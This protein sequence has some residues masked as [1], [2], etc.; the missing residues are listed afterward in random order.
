MKSVL[1]NGNLHHLCHA[2][3][4]ASPTPIAAVDGSGH[5][6]RYVNPAFC[7][8]TG[9]DKANLIGCAFSSVLSTEDDCLPMLARVYR[10]G[11]PEVHIGHDGSIEHPLFWSYTMSPIL[12]TKGGRIGIFIRVSESTPNHRD[13]VAM[14]QALLVSSVRQHELTEA[15]VV[16][17]MQLQEQ[18]LITT[19][20]QAALIRTEKLASVGR[21]A[22]VIA[23]EINNPLDAVMNTV[24]LALTTKG[25]PEPA[26]QYLELAEDELKRIAHI[27][28]QTLGFY[29]EST[30]PSTFFIAP[31]L[32]SVLDLLRA[33]AKSSHAVIQRRCDEQLQ[34]TAVAG[35]LRQVFANLLLNSLDAIPDRGT[36][37]LRCSRSSRSGHP[38]HWVRVTIAD[39]GGGIDA[40]TLPNIFEAFFTTKGAIGNG[41]GLWV[42]KQII[43]KHGGSIRARSNRGGARTGTVFS[44]ILPVDPL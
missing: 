36:V 26:R 21:M 42:S 24:Y 17:N 40:D 19:Q 9:K 41:L 37:K 29:R 14:N 20:A 28:R 39:N 16:L 27:T 22:A 4:E 30:Q 11:I 44:V 5:L 43:E 34:I 32:D 6:I 7:L 8:L 3:S 13:A 25:L 35:E 2:V 38:G 23:H 12:G 33:R 18:M 31:L 1:L 10:S 15:A